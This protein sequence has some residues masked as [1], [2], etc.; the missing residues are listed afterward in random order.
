MSNTKTFLQ[1]FIII[2][3]HRKNRD[4]PVDVHGSGGT[5]FPS[6]PKL[7][8]L[9]IFISVFL[10][11][12]T[13]DEQVSKTIAILQENKCDLDMLCTIDEKKLQSMLRVRYAG[14]KAKNL[15]KAAQIIKTKHNGEIPK[16]ISELRSL[17][18]VG[19]KMSLAMMNFIWNQCVGISVDVHI[20]RIANRIGWVQTKTEA[21][22]RKVLEALLPQKDWKEFI[23]VISGFGQQ[24]C[25]KTPLCASCNLKNSCVSYV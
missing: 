7:R 9:Y 25:K 1:D 4:A 17:E 10:S 14:R 23:T 20:H 5:H 13:K 12:M 11:S 18:G 16:T 19:E 24:I 6:D 3:E 15:K 21:A 2:K 8:K 22:T